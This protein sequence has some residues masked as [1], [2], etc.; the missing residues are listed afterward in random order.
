VRRQNEREE[1]R[2]DGVVAFGMW[3]PQVSKKRE[4]KKRDPTCQIICDEFI[5]ELLEH[6]HQM[7]K[8]GWRNPQ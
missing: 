2:G 5:G 6:H 1:E 8:L 4:R 7:L 3:V